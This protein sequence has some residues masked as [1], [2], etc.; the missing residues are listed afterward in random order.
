MNPVQLAI[1]AVGGQAMAAKICG[2]SAPAINRWCSRGCLPRTEYTGKTKYAHLLSAA[3]N[4]KFTAEWLLEEAN[5]DR[6]I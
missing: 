4:G 2:R 3:A 5:P 1:E 6:A